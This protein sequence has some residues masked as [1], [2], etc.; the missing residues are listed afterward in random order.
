[1][2]I[3]KNIFIVN[4]DRSV[5]EDFFSRKRNSDII[6][7]HEI[8]QR[9]TNNDV[10]KTPPSREVVEFQIIKRLNSFRRCKKTEFLFFFADSVDDNLLSNLKS[11]FEGCEFPVNY[12]LL[13]DT[14]EIEDLPVKEDQ[15]S[16]VQIL[17]K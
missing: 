9:L 2:S 14:P 7:Y 3:I 12:H 6:N 1:M 13:L 8:R 16:S 11:L 10:F 15:F 4:C 17:D 5:F